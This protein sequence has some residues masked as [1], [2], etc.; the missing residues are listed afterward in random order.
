MDN[1]CA[2]RGALSSDKDA[3][4]ARGRIFQFCSLILTNFVL[5]ALLRYI[6][7]LRAVLNLASWSKSE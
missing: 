6:L 7:Y 5:P 2:Y 4:Y 3:M 1:E